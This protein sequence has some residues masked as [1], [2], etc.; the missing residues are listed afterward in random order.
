MIEQ[1]ESKPKMGVGQGDEPDVGVQPETLMEISGGKVV[2]S[3]AVEKA[4]EED[5]APPSSGL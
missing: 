5:G 1:P 4:A 2:D 3:A